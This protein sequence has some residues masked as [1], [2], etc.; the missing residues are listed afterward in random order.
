ME[1]GL[2]VYWSEFGDRLAGH[3]GL[4]SVWKETQPEEAERK[5]VEVVCEGTRLESEWEGERRAAGLEEWEAR[6]EVVNDP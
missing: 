5:E 3:K 1:K 6:W 2:A 4:G